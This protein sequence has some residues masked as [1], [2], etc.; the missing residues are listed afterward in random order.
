MQI[1]IDQSGKIEYTN[2]DT[3]I[4]YA[5]KKQKSL[6]IKA[7]DKRKIKEIFRE[8]GKPY[9]FVYKTF[10]ILIYLLIKKDLP[11][12]QRIVIDKEYAGKEP[13]IK[14]FLLQIIR[15]KSKTLIDKEDI[16]FKQIGRKNNAH[17]KAI[18]TY[19]GKDKADILVNC[20]NVLPYIL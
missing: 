16:Y 13:L 18:N 4:A 7:K 3:V 1:Y 10:A 2:K 9:I 11:K 20:K 5:N 19:Q 12:I 14:D 6:L 15:K 17:K 8:A